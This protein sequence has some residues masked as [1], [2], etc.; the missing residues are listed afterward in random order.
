MPA[1]PIPDSPYRRSV[2]V[3]VGAN[4]ASAEMEDDPH[5]F[6]AEVTF[7][8]RVVVSVRGTAVRTPW[9]TC[10]AAAAQL[11]AFEG[12]EL[13]RSPFDLLR[14]VVQ[15]RQCTHMMDLAA[16]AI[17]AAGTSEGDVERRWD[18]ELMVRA[19]DDFGFH[20]GSIVLDGGDAEQWRLE[21]G[22][23]V[24]PTRYAG[25]DLARVS[26]WVEEVESP[27]ERERL[28]VM[29]RAVPTSWSRRVDLDQFDDASE[30]DYMLGSCFT[31][32]PVRATDGKRVKG[33][34]RQFARADDPLGDRS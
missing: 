34:T 1:S 29:R 24:L 23:V 33:S 21:N 13:S 6:G 16:L 3:R 32:D 20:H 18:V 22:L 14:N 15:S 10:P 31:F 12:F 17:A 9:T 28:F 2:I 11:R 4:R 19:S 7:D 27:L 30:L 8:E 25:R 26:R 5:H